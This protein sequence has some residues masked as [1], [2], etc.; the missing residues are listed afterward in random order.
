VPSK[1]VIAIRNV[2]L[3]RWLPFDPQPTT[4]EVRAAVASVDAETG[5]VEVKA[6][7]RDLGNAFL[8]DA[9]NKVASEAVVVLADRYPDPPA[10]HPFALTEEAPCKSTIEDLRRNM[11]HGPLFQMLRTLDRVGREGI[12]GTLEV[13]PR[14]GWFRSNPDPRHAIDP[15]LLDS[16]MHII[17]AWHLEQP[18]WTG[19]IL[20]PFEMQRIEYFG[21]TP[22]V[23][24]WLLTRGHNEQESARHFR[25]G[26]EVFDPQGRLW[27]RLT[28]S[29]YWRFYLPF[30]HV[31]FFGPKDEYY[32]SRSWPEA[33]SGAE[34]GGRSAE[35]KAEE[36]PGSSLLNSAL[37]A[38]HSAFG[39][40]HFL[41]PPADLKQPVLRAA[42]ARVTMTPHELDAFWNWTGTDAELNDWF[43]G[44][45]LA[46]DAV[47][48]AWSA[49]H[50]EAMFPADMDTDEADGRIVC[51]PRGAPK[52]EPFPPVSVAVA[53][54]KVA[55]FAAF[56]ERVGI[57]L[58]VIAK[59][60]PPGAERAART[61]VA[62]S[63]LADALRIPVTGCEAESLDANDGAAVVRAMGRR[64]RV[65]TARQKDAVVATTVCEGA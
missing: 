28:G 36:S 51:K 30:G 41:E 25:H 6:D 46:K 62:C 17:G 18:D 65:Q 8:R 27:L 60:A 59:N 42:G 57:A 21:P 24:T 34:R 31:N 10:P 1:V 22:E 44:R 29:G 43:F 4:L 13:Q 26:L 39:R 54:G 61:Q 37:R 32:L 40:C 53:D 48:A 55:A 64:Y 33:A 49:K 15:V 11:F 47:R 20:L 7:V 16:A 19:R 35:L 52:V 38:P 9:T 50:R 23:G 58:Q 45:M 5:V 3:F 2:R 14:D 12:E 56:A 63:A